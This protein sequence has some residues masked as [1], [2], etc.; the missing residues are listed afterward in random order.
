M[1]KSYTINLFDLDGLDKFSKDLEEL[2]KLLDNKEFL[3]F[4]SKKCLDEV[5]RIT[6]QRLRTENYSTDYRAKHKRKISGKRIT[7]RNDS[8]VDLSHLSEETRARYAG[9]LSLAKIIEFG[10]GI[11]RN[12]QFRI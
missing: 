1:D 10:T 3:E 11:P 9:G 5:R 7:I 2:I 12:R 6:D 4:I 8:Q